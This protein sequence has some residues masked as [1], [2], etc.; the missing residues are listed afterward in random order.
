MDTTKVRRFREQV[1]HFRTRFAQGCGNAL[2]NLLGQAELERWVERHSKGSRN[3][4]YPPLVT[5]GLFVDQVMS[6]DQSC[7]DAVA[8]GV[9]ARVSQGETP[10]GLNNGP[11]CKARKRLS[12]VLLKKLCNTVAQRMLK[13]QQ[14]SWRWRRARSQ[15]D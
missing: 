11:Y 14:Q 9:S 8:R 15:I 10:C 3:R 4:I 12:H 6:A 7:Q 1:K 2:S 5:L 13:A